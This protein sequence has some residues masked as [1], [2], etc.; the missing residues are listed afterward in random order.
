[1]TE[2][3]NVYEDMLIE[4][5][6]MSTVGHIVLDLSGVLADFGAGS[7]AAFDAA[8]AVWYI[9]EKDYLYAALSLISA[10][11]FIGDLV[12]KGGKLLHSIDKGRRVGASM[13]KA[14]KVM[15]SA[16]TVGQLAKVKSALKAPQT[17]KQIDDIMAVA[18]KNEK[19]APHVDAMKQALND[20]ANENMNPNENGMRQEAEI[21][22]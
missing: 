4:E 1:M 9:G 12:G 2:L 8:N 7:G 11:P 10:I 3:E 16:K 14:G 22:T 19:L 20:F 18:S 13:Y 15:K 5:G 21:N 6:V 17:L